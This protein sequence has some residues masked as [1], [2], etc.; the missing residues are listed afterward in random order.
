MKKTKA[1]DLAYEQYHLLLTRFKS[2]GD[3]QEKHRLFR[4]LTNLLAVMD[5]LISI[6]KV[7]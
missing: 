4:R 7:Q 6:N 1:F 3:T 5:F 2:T